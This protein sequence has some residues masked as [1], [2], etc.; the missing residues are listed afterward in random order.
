MTGG[1]DL[2][3]WQWL[4][5]DGAGPLGTMRHVHTGEALVHRGALG[6]AEAEAVRPDL[7]EAMRDAPDT[8]QR[9]DYVHPELTYPLVATVSPDFSR[10]EID[11]GA[12]AALWRREAGTDRTHPTYGPFCR[13]D[14]ALLEAF[15]IWPSA[16][17]KEDGQGRLIIHGGWFNGSWQ[18]GLKRSTWCFSQDVVQWA[19]ATRRSG[20]VDPDPPPLAHLDAESARWEF[21]VETGYGPAPN[22]GASVPTSEERF[23]K[24]IINN[25]VNLSLE[26]TF[27]VRSQDKCMYEGNARYTSRPIPAF[28]FQ[29]DKFIKVD[30]P[31]IKVQSAEEFLQAFDFAQSDWW[32]PRDPRSPYMYLCRPPHLGEFP[33]TGGKAECLVASPLLISLF[34]QGQ[35]ILFWRNSRYSTGDYR[36]GWASDG[37]KIV[38]TG[39]RIEFTPGSETASYVHSL[40]YENWRLPDAARVDL[41]SQNT[42]GP[43]YHALTVTPL[44]SRLLW[45]EVAAGLSVF[46]LWA[47]ISDRVRPF[48]TSRDEAKVA[49]SVCLS[50]WLWIG[51]FY[52]HLHVICSNDGTGE[53]EFES[54]RKPHDPHLPDPRIA[55][56]DHNHMTIEGWDNR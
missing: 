47:T 52:P 20:P 17:R 18:K 28:S 29:V 12:S 37:R 31:V 21:C 11:H 26:K 19:L 41:A 45:R 14:D 46:P 39:K 6:A 27:Y 44:A 49:T 16:R 54:R 10:I 2:G 50:N 48:G 15:R 38:G 51:N 22:D 8:L 9:F 34:S 25:S 35:Q 55:E 33:G 3:W 5:S 24:E 43:G 23:K 40:F 30:F 13:V 53:Q 7:A 42:L 36:W 56:F 32:D 1:V 4:P